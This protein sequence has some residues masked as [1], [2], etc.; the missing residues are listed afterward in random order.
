MNTNPT[1]ISINK[2]DLKFQHLLIIGILSLSF[3]ISFLLRSQLT[4]F[5]WE[6]HEF[7]PFF[8]Y[9]ATQY[10]VDNGINSYFQWNDTLSWYP[11]G[12]DVSSTSQVILHLTGAIT[13]WIF[14]FGSDLYDFTIVFPVVIGSLTSIVL[15]ALVRTI[16]GTTAGLFSSLLFSISLPIIIRGQIG[17]F[18]SEPLGLFFSILAIYLFLSGLNSKNKKIVFSKLIAAAIFLIFGLSAW[19]GDQYFI[20]PLGIFLLTLPFLRKD[21]GFLLWSIPLFTLTTVLTSLGFER[22]GAHFIF[23]MGGLSL[24]VPTIF[25]VF[26]I[27]IQQKSREQK[28]RNGLLFLISILIVSSGVIALNSE[29]EFL[30]LPSFRY[31]NAINPF[32]TTTDPLIDSVAEHSTTAIEQ[33]FLFHSILMIFSAFGIWFMLKN[34]NFMKNDMISFSLILGIAGVYVS[35]AF[36]RLEV[37]ASL[38]V[39][40]LSSLG[41]SALVNVFFTNKIKINKLENLAIQLPF[42]VGIV[43]ILIIPLV[44]PFDTDIFSMTSLPPTILNGGTIYPVS[45]SDWN[46]ALMWIK[47]NTPKDAVVGAWWDYGYWIQTKSERATL[48]DNS[49]LYSDRIKE[50]AKIFLNSPD[51]AWKSLDKMNTDYFVVFV[52]GQRLAVDNFYQN[53]EEPL[54]LLEGGGEESKKQWFM[55]IAS[56]PEEKYLYSDGL[57]GTDYFWNETFLGQLIPFT[58][59]SYVDFLTGQQ[60]LTYQPGSTPIYIKDVKLSD[61]NGPL[62]LVYSSPSFDAEKGKEMI[63]V[64]VYKINKDYVPLN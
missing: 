22:L 61:D 43:F 4:E 17:W 1:L 10:I 62:K 54:Y 12:R 19:G 46:D 25:L 32:L 52:A 51:Q 60:F 63:G 36:I 8:N 9:R 14:G 7:D 55:R 23:G 57:S 11:N 53:E 64:F 39:I 47:N 40:L 16:G 5:G 37:F 35:S 34:S 13:Y 58:P 30:P 28:T 45:T 21:H 24:I 41:L 56:E 2:F 48:S 50:I 18:K 42:A 59:I 6:L 33:S 20:I 38:S 31:L 27:F 29:S 49:T 44:S 26:C 3:S 15:F